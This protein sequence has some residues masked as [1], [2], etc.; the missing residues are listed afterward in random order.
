MLILPQVI[1]SGLSLDDANNQ[2]G[3][4][5]TSDQ[6]G[7]SVDR[8]QDESDN[9]TGPADVYPRRKVTQDASG[10]KKEPSELQLSNA[11]TPNHSSHRKRRKSS[12][13]Y[14]LLVMSTI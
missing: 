5:Q 7:I 11:S 2:T 8:H 6:N 10:V 3:R 14:D 12:S 1:G 13:E 4:E 9:L